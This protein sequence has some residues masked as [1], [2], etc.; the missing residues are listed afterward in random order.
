MMQMYQAMWMMENM[1]KMPSL[2][3]LKNTNTSLKY[4]S[5]LH[6]YMD[7]FPLGGN[8]FRCKAQVVKKAIDTYVE[9]T[10]KTQGWTPTMCVQTTYSA[11]QDC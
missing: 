8:R 7:G 1:V 2:G 9:K 6:G 4:Q 5:L 3:V 11:V 10:N